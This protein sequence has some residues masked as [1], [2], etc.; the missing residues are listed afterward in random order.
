MADRPV[1][2]LKAGYKSSGKKPGEIT[3]LEIIR[4]KQT[5]IRSGERQSFTNA[6]NPR[7]T[8]RGAIKP[9][10]RFLKNYSKKQIKA[11]EVGINSPPM[12]KAGQVH[13]FV[14]ANIP[15]DVLC[16]HAVHVVRNQLGLKQDKLV[17]Q[18][19][20]LD[21]PKPLSRTVTRRAPDGLT[22]YEKKLWK[23]MQW[24]KPGFT[25]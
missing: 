24:Y 20:T 25:K 11:D 17:R 22:E 14:E 7:N 3:R 19:P 2:R 9:S 4:K 5:L 8:P 13:P 1:L 23:K 15:H 16:A 18:V 6:I 10:A 12:S 21:H